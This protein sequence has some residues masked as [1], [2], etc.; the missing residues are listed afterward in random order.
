MS[1]LLKEL[2]STPPTSRVKVAVALRMNDPD[3]DCLNRLRSMG[4]SID[5]IIGGKLL[6]SLLIADKTAIVADPDVLEV[7]EGAKLSLS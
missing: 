5:R 1:R 4:L 2:V 7:E 3:A 6:G